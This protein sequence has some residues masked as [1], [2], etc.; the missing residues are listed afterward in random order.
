M[1]IGI[2]HMKEREEKQDMRRWFC[3][4]LYIFVLFF[5]VMRDNV[6]ARCIVKIV[7]TLVACLY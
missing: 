5:V 7:S 4:C 6:S 2:R 3:L 1:D